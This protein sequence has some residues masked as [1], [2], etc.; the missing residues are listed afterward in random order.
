MCWTLRSTPLSG[1]CICT[2]A[3]SLT[4]TSSLK[5][6]L[7]KKESSN[8]PI[9][10]SVRNSQ[11]IAWPELCLAHLCTWP[12]RSW[13]GK[14]T[15][16]TQ[17]SGP[18]ESPSTKWYSASTPLVTQSSLHSLQ[19]NRP[20][21]KDKERTSDIP[22]KS[23]PSYRRCSTKDVSGRPSQTH[24]MEWSIPP[25]SDSLARRQHLAKHA[26]EFHVF[27]GRFASEYVKILH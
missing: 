25:S 19:H 2:S 10:A 3:T 11:S 14:H 15:A 20:P 9:L 21:E 18:S 23:Q 22:P 26:N 1:W 13:E 17:T 8:W 5:M 6:C 12:H 24:R 27:Q 16:T 7:F 4:A